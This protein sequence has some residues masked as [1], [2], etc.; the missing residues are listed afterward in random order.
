LRSSIKSPATTSEPPRPLF[1][2]PRQRRRWDL[3]Q[4]IEFIGDLARQQN[5][6]AEARQRFQDA[7]VLVTQLV[8]EAPDNDQWALGVSRLYTSMGD[9][10]IAADLAAAERD[11]GNSMT[12]AANYFDRKQGNE[13]WQRELAWPYA[14]LA[15]VNQKRGDTLKDPADA[16][17][18]QAS[19]ATALDDLENSVCLRRK[20]AAAEPASTE[21]TRDV[22]Y[23]LDRVGAIKDRLNDAAGAELAYFE[24]LAIRR[25]LVA[26]I[27][28]N[29]L[30]VGDVAISL[31]WIGD[32]YLALGN[33]Q[34]ALAFYDAA[35]AARDKVVS[36]APD[37]VQALKNAAAANKKAGDS[38]AKV[39]ASGL[40]PDLSVNWWQAAV[41]QAEVAV[42]P[43][44][45]ANAAAAKDCMTKVDASVAQIV[46]LATA[47][48]H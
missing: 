41:D 15:D 38:Q 25:G 33:N 35:A 17:R 19:Y 16:D 6:A 11:Y 43:E 9:L 47:S 48:V 30:Y 40:V 45:A 24:S 4:S 20:V 28:D 46:G 21:Y 29:A 42:K 31:T 34:S 26:K 2:Q 37:D 8:K 27:P 23:T 44:I 18:R 39:I 36:L 10:D 14:K 32:H 1:S 7:L 3:S 12:L 22:S 13:I 5:K